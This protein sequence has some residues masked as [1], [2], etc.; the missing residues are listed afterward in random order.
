LKNKERINVLKDY[1]VA[2]ENIVEV[3]K[4]EFES[5]T[6][7]FVDIL[8]AQTVLYEAKKSLV[9]R[10]YELYK[11][12]YDILLFL[13]QGQYFYEK[14]CLCCYTWSFLSTTKRKPLD[15]GN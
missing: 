12:Y 1:V 7:T 14:E 2:N 15:N 5:G 9:N 6:R 13:Q 4:S 11:N 8:D 10:E 3:Y